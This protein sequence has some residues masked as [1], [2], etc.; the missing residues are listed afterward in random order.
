MILNQWLTAVSHGFKILQ[1]YF[2]MVDNFQA[3]LEL[4]SCGK[5]PIWSWVSLHAELM[6]II[7]QYI[8]VEVRYVT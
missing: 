3:I 5:K 8:T 6:E 1:V 2:T 7:K 4:N